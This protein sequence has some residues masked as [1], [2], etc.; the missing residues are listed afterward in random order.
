[1]SIRDEDFLTPELV[2]KWLNKIRA[3]PIT[4]DDPFKPQSLEDYIGQEK[5]KKIVSVVVNAAIKEK[6][7]LPN[8]LITGPYGQ[9]KTSLARIM[10]D[11]YE[12]NIPL[13][14]AASVN[15]TLITEGMYIVDEIH[16]LG[17]DICDSLNIMLDN[18][19]LHIIGCSTNAGALPAAFRS[20]FRQIYLEPYTKADIAKIIS[21]VIKVKELTIQTKSLE[22]IA[23]RSRLNPR[24]ALNYLAY[25]FDIASLQ[26]ARKITQEIV[27][28]AFEQLG[29]DK[30]GFLS[31]D[32]AYLK[33]LPRN[34]RA[35][36]LQ[37]LSAVTSIDPQTIEMEVEPYLLQQG[38]IDRTPKGRKLVNA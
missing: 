19:K 18:N 35:V 20:R 28:D 16:N 22:D 33:A 37:Y 29:V 8:T 23:N 6:R 32:Y 15:K 3:V 27:E 7:P 13:I 1:M 30:Y 11:T 38:L 5:A 24:T 12:R 14:D 26:S 25:V 4:K 2:E 21:R 9:G 36:G 10:A 31:R 34:G 17:A